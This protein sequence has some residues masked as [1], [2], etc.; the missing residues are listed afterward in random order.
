MKFDT[1]R[2]GTVDV[3]ENRIITMSQDLLGFPG[4]RR[5]CIIQH[6]EDSPFFWYQSLDD[7]ALAFVITNPWLFKPDY[8]VDVERVNQTMG[9]KDDSEDIPAECYVFVTIP[10][11]SPEKMTANLV[12]PLIIN[13]TTREAVQVILSD[14]TYSYK[15]PLVEKKAAA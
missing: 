9:W 2:F 10:R 1:T 11:G 5:F 7:P 12:G 8:K 6:K 3:P 14:E 15:Y 4:K 13:N